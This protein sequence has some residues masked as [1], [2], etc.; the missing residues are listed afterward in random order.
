MEGLLTLSILSQMD[1]KSR[2][3]RETRS[4]GSSR[5]YRLLS[6][7]SVSFPM[8][9]KMPMHTRHLRLTCTA[10]VKRQFHFKGLLSMI[11]CSTQ[12][13]LEPPL[14]SHHHYDQAAAKKSPH[15]FLRYAQQFWLSH[16]D[17]GLN[18]PIFQQ[19]QAR[20]IRA[21]GSNDFDQSSLPGAQLTS[22]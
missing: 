16:C 12:V 15:T 1:H 5:L 14:T 20:T 2:T 18:S 21:D 4:M 13:L 8:L 17:I 10:P 11:I 19:P 9:C 3:L 6:C 7:N 22:Q